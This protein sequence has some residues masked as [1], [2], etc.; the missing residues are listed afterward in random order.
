MG[1]I[2]KRAEE[3][4]AEHATT[5]VDQDGLRE[6]VSEEAAQRIVDRVNQLRMRDN[7]TDNERQAAWQIRLY[8]ED[9][10]QHHLFVAL[11]RL[12]SH[13]PCPACGSYDHDGWR[14]R[15][16]CPEDWTQY[17]GFQAR[18]QVQLSS[19]RANRHLT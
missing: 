17:T 18:R 9:G 3:L 10:D 16:G 5:F 6:S 13:A 15:E 7:D 1:D 19:E 11:D 8:L 14:N 2:R 12:E 4:L